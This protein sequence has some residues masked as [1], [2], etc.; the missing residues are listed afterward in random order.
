MHNTD[1]PEE[2]APALAPKG[3]WIPSRER[4]D[5]V[6]RVIEEIES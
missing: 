1:G 2:A 3:P 6:G 5:G 4:L